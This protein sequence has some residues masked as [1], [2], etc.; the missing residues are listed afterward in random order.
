MRLDW[1]AEAIK[2]HFL[3][4]GEKFGFVWKLQRSGIVLPFL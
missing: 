3:C 1:A 2:A 4:L